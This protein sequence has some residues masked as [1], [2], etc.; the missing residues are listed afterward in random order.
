MRFGGLSLRQLASWSNRGPLPP[1]PSSAVVEVVESLENRVPLLSNNSIALLT[2]DSRPPAPSSAVV[3]VVES[4]A[5][6][7]RPTPA[8]SSAVVV[9]V[10]SVADGLRPTPAPSSAVV[11]SVADGLRTNCC[12]IRDQRVSVVADVRLDMR[13][14]RASRR[15]TVRRRSAFTRHMLICSCRK[16]ISSRV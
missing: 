4:V 5:D 11:E 2:F 1:A 6:G 16:V 8:P 7:L 14:E 15:L 3:V 9:V 13:W 12:D 10:E